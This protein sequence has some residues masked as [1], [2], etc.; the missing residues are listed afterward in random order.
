MAFPQT[1]EA[2]QTTRSYE[3]LRKLEG[4]WALRGGCLVTLAVVAV[5]G[6]VQ[7][8]VHFVASDAV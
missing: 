6:A 7:P 8:G 1:T 4:N 2:S 3:K 5:L